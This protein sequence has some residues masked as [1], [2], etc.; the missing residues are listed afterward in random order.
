MIPGL[1]TLK[2]CSTLNKK[3]LF[4]ADYK[5]KEDNKKRRKRLRAKKM[6]KIDKDLETEGVMY[7][8]GGF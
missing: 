8:A 4:R 1:Y 7:E 5:N 3:R 6:G 2:G